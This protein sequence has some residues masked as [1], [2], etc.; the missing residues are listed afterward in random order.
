VV[1]EVATVA[2]PVTTTPARQAP[3]GYIT[4][5]DGT[6]VMIDMG[7]AQGLQ[8]GAHLAVYKA[9][10]TNTRVGV[11]EITHVVDTGTSRA[12]I[13]TMNANVKPEFSDLV[14]VE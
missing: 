5:V 10:D 9:T 6:N 13:V 1:G 14:R 3:Q 12:R 2:H 11:I 4:S 7:S 8:Q